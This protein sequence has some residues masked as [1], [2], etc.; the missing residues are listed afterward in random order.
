MTEQESVD[1][2]LI[3]ALAA[4]MTH[5]MAGTLAGVASK[6]VQRRLSNDSFVAEIARR[7]AVRVDEVTG[8]LSELSVR[9]LEVLEECLV[10]S[11]P[12]VRL[13]AAEMTFAWFRRLRD[14]VDVDVRLA[15]LERISKVDTVDDA[16]ATSEVTS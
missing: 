15:R 7:R 6:T 14:E 2:V 5:A 4:G 3:A 8:R 16:E 1:E 13:R 12:T 10:S 9:A 11:S